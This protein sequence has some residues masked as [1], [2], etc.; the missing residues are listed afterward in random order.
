MVEGF[1][2]WC[3]KMLISYL[4]SLRLRQ[5]LQNKN[6]NN[7]DLKRFDLWCFKMWIS[8]LASLRVRQGQCEKQL[9]HSEN[10]FDLQS[11]I[12]GFL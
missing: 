5:G 11:G 12:F 4:A 3:L 7:S 2:L 1:D 10:A 8:Y 6:F 9:G